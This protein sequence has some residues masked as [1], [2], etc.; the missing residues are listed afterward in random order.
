MQSH[1]TELRLRRVLGC[2]KNTFTVLNRAGI[3]TFIGSF[4]QCV[5]RAIYGDTIK[6]TTEQH[7][8]NMQLTLALN[9]AGIP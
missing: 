7:I 2:M 8:A 5:A 4:E 9:E 1:A 6:R 3:P